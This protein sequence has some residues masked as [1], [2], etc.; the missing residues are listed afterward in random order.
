MTVHVL[1]PN[2]RLLSMLEATA[3]CRGDRDGAQIIIEDAAW[4]SPR[5]HEFAAMWSA[6]AT[7]DALQAR[8]APD[9]YTH[10]DIKNLAAILT[11]NEF[12]LPPIERALFVLGGIGRRDDTTHGGFRINTTPATAQMIV[13]AANRVLWALG[14]PKIRYPIPTKR[15]A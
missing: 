5:W 3:G 7:I 9:G 13:A 15:E 8:F 1:P 11:G 10:A 6:G 4:S 12:I 2:A 14:L